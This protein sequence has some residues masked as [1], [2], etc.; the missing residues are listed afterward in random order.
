[1]STISNLPLLT[2]VTG[3]IVIPVADP[4]TSTNSTKSLTVQALGEFINEQI[5]TVNIIAATTTTLGGVIVGEGLSVDNEG[6]LTVVLPLS[7]ATTATLGGV[8]VGNGLVIDNEGVLSL[9]SSIGGLGATGATGVGATGAT[10]LV[11][12]TGLRGLTGATGPQGIPGTAAAQGSTGATGLTG[13][14]GVQGI[15]GTAAFQGST[16]ATGPRLVAVISIVKPENPEAG[17]LWLDIGNSGQLLTY[18]GEVWVSAAPGGGVGNTGATGATGLTGSTGATGATGLDGSTGATGPQGIIGLDGATGAT[19][20]QGA[21]GSG[22]TGSTGFTGT[23]GATGLT[24]ATGPQGDPGGATGPQGPQGDIGS[25]GATGPQGSTGA[26]GLGATGATGLLGTTGATGEQGATGATGIGSTGATGPQGATGL[27]IIGST[28]ETG[29][30]GLGATGA[31]GLDGL[32]GATGATGLIGATGAGATGATGIGSTGATGLE[33][34]TGATGATGEH[35]S[36]GA[37]GL[38]GPAGA[39]GLEG[40]TGATGAGATGATGLIGATGSAGIQGATGATGSFENPTTNI[41]TIT[42]TTE[43]MSTITGALQVAGGAG[44]GGNLNVGGAI[45]SNGIEI[46]GLST[47]QQTSEVIIPISNAQSTVTHDFSQGATWYHSSIIDNFTANFTNVPTTNN[48]ATS[49]VLILDQGSTPYIS[50]AVQIGSESQTILWKEGTIPTGTANHRDLVSFTFI[51]T[52][53]LWTVLGSLETYAGVG[54][55]GGGDGTAT[56]TT[57]NQYTGQGLGWNTGLDPNIIVVIP[58]DWTDTNALNLLLSQPSGTVYNVNLDVDGVPSTGTLT[59]TSAWTD[60]GGFFTAT[61]TSTGLPNPSPSF[62]FIDSISFSSGGGPATYTSQRGWNS[63][64]T[65][66]DMGSSFSNETPDVWAASSFGWFDQNN[67]NTLIAFTSGT[68]FTM[69]FRGTTYNGTLTSDFIEDSFRRIATVSWTGAAPTVSNY[70]SPNSFTI[71]GITYF[72]RS[73][74]QT[75]FD[76]LDGAV[77]ASTTELDVVGPGAWS[78]PAEFN[79]VIALTTSAEISVVYRGNT[80]TGTLSS[81]FTVPD[82]EFDPDRRTALITWQSSSGLETFTGSVESITIPGGG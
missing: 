41:V 33:G 12:A 69:N 72:N 80:Y 14:T 8:I 13:A 74:Y 25:T 21:T 19:G 52:N 81:D 9:D 55:G 42:N 44:I 61:V 23:T 18:N 1:M 76:F 51:R 3:Q 75:T 68:S 7:T 67:Y 66:G 43:S 62:W 11:G 36:T 49:A 65:Y 10:G 53:S 17:D 26:T 47:L 29:A 28:G 63:E 32:P 15:P 71:G 5:T 82:P 27:S 54:G 39:T 20:P 77:R 50:N 58:D 59:T 35:G 56:F 60:E 40:S 31:T 45:K 37:T 2:S 30:T 6:K 70:D 78:D 24:G 79:S 38:E 48:R 73:P 64:G 16:G 22:A 57:G 34:S 46:V 4:T